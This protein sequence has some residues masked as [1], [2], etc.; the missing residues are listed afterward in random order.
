MS[1]A[2]Q[3]TPWLA[4]LRRAL[5]TALWVMKIVI[6]TSL[7]V[8]LLDYCGL[9]AAVSVYTEPFF[10]L[11]GLPGKA[12]IAYLSSIFL[13]LYVPY[14]LISSLALNL[15]QATILA[16]MC[17]LAHNLPVEAAVQRR[18]G[19]PLW[20]SLPLRIGFSLFGGFLLNLI[21]PEA[22]TLSHPLI[23]TAAA[24]P[25]SLSDAL[26][27]WAMGTASLCLKLILII[28]AL[29]FLQDFLKRHGLIQ[30]ISRSLSPFMKFCGLKPE[31]SFIWLI[32]NIVGLTYGAGIMAQ[33]VEQANAD[34]EELRRINRHIAL[35]HSLLEDTAIF[36]MLGVGWYWLII[37]RLLFALTAVWGGRLIASVASRHTT[38]Q[39]L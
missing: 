8:T 28:T 39:Q 11:I 1:T 24:A 17:L 30:I 32:A 6:P 15:R 14:A 19:L 16:L 21:L 35:N 34:R 13:P 2:P 3:P 20:Q 10:A 18:C 23:T 25:L 29:M 4:V 33:E 9:I 12:A 5:H 31:S 27:S 26:R 36:V 37:P 22:L 7:V 38:A